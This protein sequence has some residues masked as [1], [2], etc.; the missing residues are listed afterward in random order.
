MQTFVNNNDTIKLKTAQ[1]YVYGQLINVSCLKLPKTISY[2]FYSKDSF[3]QNYQERVNHLLLDLYA[4]EDDHI[5][6]WDKVVKEMPF[7]RSTHNVDEAYHYMMGL[8]AELN[9]ITKDKARTIP[10]TRRVFYDMKANICRR[11]VD[12]RDNLVT[13]WMEEDNDGREYFVLV[14]KN[15]HGKHWVFHQPERNFHDERLTLGHPLR[16]LEMRDYHREDQTDV[17]VGEN[18]TLK[19]YQLMLDKLDIAY[20]YYINNNNNVETGSN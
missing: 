1:R 9:D 15:K 3:R 2:D 6:L 11:L 4:S 19:D 17:N 14:F 13:A 20:H 7:L 18:F 5:K 10:K 12:W 16:G 8:L